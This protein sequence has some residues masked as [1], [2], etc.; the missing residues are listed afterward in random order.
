MLASS[1]LD[2]RAIDLSTPTLG[3]VA[4][5]NE[6]ALLVEIRPDGVW[7]AAESLA[8]AALTQRVSE[9][10]ATKP[11]QRILLKPSEGVSLQRTVEVL[12]R[13]KMAGVTNMSLIR[14]G[15]E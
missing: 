14:D 10:L 15:M 11:D 7:L 2:W 5:S 4:T 12:D 1:F 13:L 9:R 6:G 3:A 8:L